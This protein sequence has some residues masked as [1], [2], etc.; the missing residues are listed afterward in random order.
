MTNKSKTDHSLDAAKGD[1]LLGLLEDL[2]QINAGKIKSDMER[3][4]ILRFV[5]DSIGLAQDIFFSDTEEDL[6]GVVE[7]AA[8]AR[9]YVKVSDAKFDIMNALARKNI[10]FGSKGYMANDPS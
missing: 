2:G 6:Q 8:L 7:R 5:L 4:V 3:D 10:V 1:L 9:E